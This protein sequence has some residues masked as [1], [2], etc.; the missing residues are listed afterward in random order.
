MKP[1]ERV[2]GAFAH[3][4]TDRVTHCE[5]CIDTFLDELKQKDL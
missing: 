2:M 5:I 3:D 4:V 1:R